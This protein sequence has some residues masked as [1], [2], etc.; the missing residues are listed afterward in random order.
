MVWLLLQNYN[1][2]IHYISNIL[3]YEHNIISFWLLDGISYLRDILS[4][5]R[6]TRNMLSVYNITN[7]EFIVGKCIGE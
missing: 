6:V 3:F 4:I 7:K 1:M 2:Y 5:I